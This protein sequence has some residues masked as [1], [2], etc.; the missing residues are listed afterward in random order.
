M[1]DFLSEHEITSED[2]AP[3][4]TAKCL[5]FLVQG[6]WSSSPHRA[7]VANRVAF[8]F[9]YSPSSLASFA[10]SKWGMV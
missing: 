10:A 7:C 1:I 5:S 8:P 3:L 6:G 9:G 2:K 4:V